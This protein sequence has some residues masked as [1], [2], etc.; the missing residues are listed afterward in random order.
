VFAAL[1]GGAVGGAA[2]GYAGAQAGSNGD[3]DN[4]SGSLQQQEQVQPTESKA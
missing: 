2:G 4:A 1:V 3:G